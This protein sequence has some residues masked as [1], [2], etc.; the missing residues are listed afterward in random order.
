[1][2]LGLAG[3]CA[4]VNRWHYAERTVEATWRRIDALFDLVNPAECRNDFAN[5]G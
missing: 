3:R 4:N 2:G 5:A 1:M